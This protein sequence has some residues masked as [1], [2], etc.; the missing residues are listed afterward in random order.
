MRFPLLHSLI[1]LL[2]AGL[3]LGCPARSERATE[4]PRSPEPAATVLVEVAGRVGL[5]FVHDNGAR[6][7]FHYPEIVQGGGAFLDYDNDSHLDIYLVQ[8]GP[9]SPGGGEPAAVNRL[10]RN[11]G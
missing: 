10:F 11:R 8:S 3:C 9:L 2:C 4:Q 6:G 7:D 1:I 5:D